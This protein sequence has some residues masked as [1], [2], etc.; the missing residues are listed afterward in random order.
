M[1]ASNKL[2]FAQIQHRHL[3]LPD[4]KA[5]ELLYRQIKERDNEICGLRAL[6]QNL[7]LTEAEVRDQHKQLVRVNAHLRA[8]KRMK[9][10]LDSEVE[11]LKTELELFKGDDSSSDSDT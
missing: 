1:D 2:S 8:W 5:F 3:Q 11:E 6:E 7:I 10:E 9:E 4:Y